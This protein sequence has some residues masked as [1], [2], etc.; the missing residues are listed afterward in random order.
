MKK[1]GSRYL[2]PEEIAF[3]PVYMKT[4]HRATV[5]LPG[6]AVFSLGLGWR[7]MGNSGKLNN[8]YGQKTAGTANL[9]AKRGMG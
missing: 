5:F 1:H 9:E 3:V 2:Q 6:N 8:N 7:N 4:R